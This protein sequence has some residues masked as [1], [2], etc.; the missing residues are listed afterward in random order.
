MLHTLFYDTLNVDFNLPMWV[1][2]L[3]KYG[4]FFLFNDV[5]PEFGVVAC[6]PIPIAEI[7]REEGF[8]SNDPA[9]VRFRWM[10]QGNRVLENWQASVNTH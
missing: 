9:A 2:N 1:R 6:Y 8:D 3:C 7:E 4:D 10:T 5:S